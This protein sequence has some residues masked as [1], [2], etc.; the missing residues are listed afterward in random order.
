MREGIAE[1]ASLV[2]GWSVLQGEGYAGEFSS[3]EEALKD[4][5]E[6]VGS[7]ET[8]LLM[9]G[10][11]EDVASLSPNIVNLTENLLEDMGERSYAECGDLG[12]EWPSPSQE[13]KEELASALETAI[14][15]WMRKHLKM[16]AWTPAW[17]DPKVFK[18]VKP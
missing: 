9:A 7:E 11:Y 12:E 8:I 4:A 13:E 5:R 3:E 1:G 18:G 17:N 2:Y 14:H 16:P 6:H 10:R 15:G